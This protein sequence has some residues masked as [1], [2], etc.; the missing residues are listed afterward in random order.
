MHLSW[1]DSVKLVSVLAFEDSCEA[2]REA[3]AGYC[4]ARSWL[5]LPVPLCMPAALQFSEMLMS[6]CIYQLL[7]VRPAEEKNNSIRV[8]LQEHMA[9]IDHGCLAGRELL[10][11]RLSG[12]QSDDLP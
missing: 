5:N 3:D 1:L 10:C 4:Q 11:K 9:G 8:M 12:L 6:A 7:E 2:V